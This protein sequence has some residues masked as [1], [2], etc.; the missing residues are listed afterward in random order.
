MKLLWRH[1]LCVLSLVVLA[2]VQASVG[3]GSAN[4]SRKALSSYGVVLGAINKVVILYFP[5]RILTRT[6][7]TPERLEHL[8]QYKLEI[9]DLPSAIQREALLAQ[10]NKT[11]I[12]ISGRTPDVR[13][14]VLL[15]DGAGRRVASMYFAQGGTRGAINSDAGAITGGVYAWAKSVMKGFSK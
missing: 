2:S 8:Y 4:P 3:A 12:S 13:T 7:I 9:R 11:S 15:Y 10:L 5:E 1:R 14:A 6:A